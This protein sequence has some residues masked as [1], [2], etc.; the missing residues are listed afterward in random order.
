M[1]HGGGSCTFQHMS[2]APKH[3]SGTGIVMLNLGG[4]ETLADV[5]PF[6][7]RLFADDA[8]RAMAADGIT[9][10]VAFTQYPQ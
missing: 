6:L 1:W 4:P 10:A 5:Q 8:L 3:H 2:K 9:R 7:E